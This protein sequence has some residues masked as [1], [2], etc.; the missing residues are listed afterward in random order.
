MLN[1]SVNFTE[2]FSERNL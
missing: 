1:A 2:P